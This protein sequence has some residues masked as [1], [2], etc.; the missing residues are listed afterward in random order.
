[1]RSAKSSP[2]APSAVDAFMVKLKHPLKAEIA[3]VR[4]V[5][6]GADPAIG[7][8]IKWNAPSFRTTEFFATVNLRATHDVQ[9]IF[10]LG[11]KVRKP[12]PKIEIADPAGLVKWLGK[13]KDRC[14]VTVGAGKEF[15]ANLKPF[16]ELVREWIKHV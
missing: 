2:A 5:I 9:L 11:A 4:Q 13:G 10:H 6:L 15:A 16:Q 12:A 3:A 1:M 7:E 8:E 14:L